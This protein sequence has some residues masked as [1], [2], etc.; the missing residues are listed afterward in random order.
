VAA[1]AEKANIPLTSLRAIFDPMEEEF[2]STEPYDED[3]PFSYL[4]RNPK[5][6]WKIPRYVRAGAICRNHLFRVV[7][8]F[9]DGYVSPTEK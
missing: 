4:L 6:F 9:I 3:H 5:V 8:R 7:S 1:V 2:P